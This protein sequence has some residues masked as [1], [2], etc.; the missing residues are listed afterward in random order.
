M[1][2]FDRFYKGASFILGQQCHFEFYANTTKTEDND[3]YIY[4]YAQEVKYAILDGNS[5]LLE[6]LDSEVDKLSL[7]H[8]DLLVQL[9]DSESCTEAKVIL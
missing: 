9:L 4:E 3:A 8:S 7:G 5:N 6:T 1:L 2:S